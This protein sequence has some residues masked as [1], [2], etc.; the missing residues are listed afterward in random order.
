MSEIKTANIGLHATGFTLLFAACGLQIGSLIYPQYAIR[1]TPGAESVTSV[2]LTMGV[3]ERCSYYPT[4][5]LEC[6]PVY[7]G[8]HQFVTSI[9]VL[10]TIASAFMIITLFTSLIGGNCTNCMYQDY[11]VNPA[12]QKM[13]LISGIASFFA[14]VFTITTISLFLTEINGNTIFGNFIA[15]AN[16]E[17][18]N[19]GAVSVTTVGISLILS[20]IACGLCACAAGLLIWSGI[21]KYDHLNDNYPAYNPV[22][23]ENAGN[24]RNENDYNTGYYPDEDKK[25]LGDYI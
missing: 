6:M 23:V 17:F 14:F 8:E 4:G 15:V 10:A 18:D 19:T 7:A 2:K 25:E 12:K 9:K 20:G 13:L 1:T 3:F 5:H 22:P 21:M 11:V 16:S 24:Y